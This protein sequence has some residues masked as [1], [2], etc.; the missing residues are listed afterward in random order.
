MRGAARGR[1]Y[2]EDWMLT[3]LEVH[4]IPVSGGVS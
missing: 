4:A 3:T 2:E 1:I